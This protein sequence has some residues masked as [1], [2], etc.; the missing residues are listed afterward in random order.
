MKKK[1]VEDI[2]LGQTTLKEEIQSG[3]ITIQKG[4]RNQVEEFFSY[5]ELST[6]GGIDNQI[7]LLDR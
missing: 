4:D 5:F 6:S 1:M 2:L 7:V 3:R